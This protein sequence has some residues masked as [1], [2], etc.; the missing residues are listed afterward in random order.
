[1]KLVISLISQ[2]AIGCSPVIPSTSPSQYPL[3]IFFLQRTAADIWFLYL[4]WSRNARC[5]SCSVTHLVT[6]VPQQHVAYLRKYILA[7]KLSE[8]S[9]RAWK[10]QL[11]QYGRQISP[12]I[13]Q[14]AGNWFWHCRR[15]YFSEVWRRQT[16]DAFLSIVTRPKVQLRT[17]HIEGILLTLKLPAPN[18]PPWVGHRSCDPKGRWALEICIRAWIPSLD[19]LS[20]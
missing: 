9:G 2:N 14:A 18:S 4:S 12:I 20:S 6:W 3:S 15:Y 1:M 19:L 11:C 8:L 13:K 5:W 17:V 7:R 16:G 10:E